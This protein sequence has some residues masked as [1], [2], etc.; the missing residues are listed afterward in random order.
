MLKRS[1]GIQEL[2]RPDSEEKNIFCKLLRTENSVKSYLHIMFGGKLM[3]ISNHYFPR[4]IEIGEWY[5][6]FSSKGLGVDRWVR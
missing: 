1:S 2:R 4:P 3:G 5:F 6:A